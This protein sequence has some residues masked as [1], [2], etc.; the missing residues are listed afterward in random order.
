MRV[1]ITGGTGLIGRA[2]AFDL[3]EDGHDVT[4]LSRDPV[5]AAGLPGGVR[6]ERWD[7]ET[8]DG[9]GHLADGADAI[10]NLA[11]ENIAA[12]RW[13][14]QQKQRIRA[15]RLN[16]GRAVVQAVEAAGNKP[17]VVIQASG[18]GIYGKH[19]DEEVT[20]DTPAGG[21]FL[22]RLAVEWEASTSRI[23]EMGVRWA[24]VRTGIVLSTGGGALPRMM[25]PVRLL[26]AGRFGSGRQ[27][28]PWI[29]IADE[30]KAIRFIIESKDAGGPFNLAA[31]YPVTN[32][33]FARYLG[34][35]LGRP[36][37][38]PVPALAL[39][40]VL[41]EMA[42]EL[43]GGQRA[44]PRNLGQIGFAFHFTDVGDALQD[45]LKRRR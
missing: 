26:F 32:A 34:W 20:E 35:A 45:L 36:V 11:G 10:V 39:R 24:A 30:V 40:L 23:Q 22:A 7:A 16:A 5:K 9:W 19:G 15:S 43:L 3:I 41:G 1:L 25:L 14:S 8:S 37:L 12:G 29:H 21:D 4:V 2:L 33:G 42:Q 31:P 18:V 6:L 27:W 28:F 17:G 38:V 13:T 44:V